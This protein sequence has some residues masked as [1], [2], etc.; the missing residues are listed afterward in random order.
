MGWVCTL[1]APLP[2][3]PRG[4]HLD[5]ESALVMP[6]YRAAMPFWRGEFSLTKMRE[7]IISEIGEDGLRIALQEFNKERLERE[8]LGERRT[9]YEIHKVLET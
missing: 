9:Y 4:F 3:L 8:S 6:G 7:D 5:S 2:I 1:V